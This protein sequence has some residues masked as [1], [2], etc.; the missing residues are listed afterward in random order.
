MNPHQCSLVKNSIEDFD[1]WSETTA[2]WDTVK[3]DGVTNLEKY[4][5]YQF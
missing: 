3:V 5:F 2:K 1:A 4:D